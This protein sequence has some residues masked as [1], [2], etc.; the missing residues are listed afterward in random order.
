MIR[1]RQLNNYF[2]MDCGVIVKNDDDVKKWIRCGMQNSRK[3]KSVNGYTGPC[4]T[5]RRGRLRPNADKGMEMSKV[6]NFWQ[7]TF[8]DYPLLDYEQKE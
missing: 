6:G 3:D 5:L 2:V 4:C 1:N 7:T 8:M